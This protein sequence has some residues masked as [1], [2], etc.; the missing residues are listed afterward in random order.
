MR[1]D[2]D[3]KIEIL[4]KQ[5]AEARKEVN[6]LKLAVRAENLKVKISSEYSNF[7]LWEYD[8]ADDICYQYKK[9]DGIY[10][11]DLEPIVH[12]RDSIIGWG[13]V[14]SDDIPVFHKF[15]DAME[16][17][18][19]EICYDV[20]VVNDY[21]EIVW[22]RYEGKTIYDDNGN[23]LR[24]V[25]RTLDVTDKKGG[26]GISSDDRRDP[27]TGAYTYE[28]FI[29]TAVRRAAE[30]DFRNSALIVV[31]I[32]RFDELC[33]SDR[34]DTDDVQ[35]S[36][37]KVLEA[38]SSVEQGS[39]FARVDDGLFVYYVKFSD[40]PNLNAIASRLIY[41]F[42]D[43]RLTD[44]ETGKRITISAGISLF[45]Y[46]RKYDRIYDEALAALYAAALKGGNGYLQYNSA[47]SIKPKA[48]DDAQKAENFIG[49]VGAEKIYHII[50]SAITDKANSRTLADLAIQQVCK[51][52]NS[53]YAYL[54]H[55]NGDTLEPD[56]I[57]NADS[58]FEQSDGL[59]AT[60]PV[61]TRSEMSELLANNKHV[62]MATDRSGHKNYGFEFVNGAHNAMVSPIY[63]R[64]K[65]TY[66]LVFINDSAK[67]WQ[68]A[69]AEIIDMLA[70]ALSYIADREQ[71][72]NR[73]QEKN[74][75]TN[76]VVNG[77][78][79]EAFTIDPDTFIV[80]KAGENTVNEYGI[81]HGDICYKKLRGLE[82][83]CADCPVHQINA[84]QITAT[85]V[86]YNSKD[87]RWLNVAAS[88][89]DTTDG[90]RRC[91]VST[92]DMTASLDKIQSRD[93][94]TGVLGF[95]RFAVDA[96]RIT[97]QNSECRFVTVVNI[98]N[99]RRLNENKGYEFGNSV[100]IAVS[101]ILNGSLSGDELICRSE[102]AR[103]VIL[104]RN[105]SAD[106][107]LPRLKQILQSAQSQ[108]EEKC[109]IQIFLV[110][111][112]YQMSGD[113]IGIMASLDRAIIAQKTV[114]DKAYY[115][116]N[117]IVFY[118]KQLQDDLQTRQYIE[119]HM[120]EALENDEFKVFYQPKVNPE[121]GD[122]VGAEALVRWIRPDGEMISPGKFV[123]IFEQNGFIADMDFAIYRRAIADIKRWMRAGI[124]APL[125]SL[126]VS[127][128]HMMDD[129]FPDKICALV[130]NL[131]VPRSKI[132]L[133]ITESML[134]ENMNKL[135]DSM[136]CLKNAGFH[137]SVDDFG[138]GYSSLNLIT[139]LPFDTLKI[140]GGFFLRNKLTEKNKAVITSVMEMAK[141]LNLTTVSEGVETDEQVEFLR[142][143]GCDMIQGYYYYKP[144]PKSDFEALISGKNDA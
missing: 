134:T 15:C 33:E 75:F 5:L 92:V 35:R 36:V 143:L 116:T 65:L 27:L 60:V 136:T 41:R 118:D 31:G 131:G 74:R 48:K 49:A 22:F 9:L 11:N 107:L 88:L 82:H 39:L 112:I 54:Y 8:I 115:N 12:F 32:D 46:S 56:L 1:N 83:P 97:A 59:P 14:Y 53:A 23:P 105:A 71:Q 26:T 121:T 117:M 19:K 67:T 138:S 128:H 96:M 50:N 87:N 104:F 108:V 58:I 132:E 103:F 129:T 37:A 91:A 98:A 120:N 127:R 44:N 137:I 68:T 64:N 85:S 40:I 133:E 144:M 55:Y 20:R 109:G 90:S 111:G 4:E 18:D 2:I 141:N 45:G 119:S 140:D 61:C 52:T 16:R 24:V 106:E 84:G 57:C 25:G 79:V 135:L 95:D 51:Y 34:C 47:M 139:L 76:A 7:G 73:L 110:A 101:D 77:L 28:A 125:I 6:A 89:M 66:I 63:V 93:T 10:E 70:C 142:S 86:H 123:P 62:S 17:G 43:F 113:N 130:D 69:D 78:G 13:T 38:Q 80:D 42:H 99:F 126:N 21:S 100:L 122:I 124:E 102:G 3:L 114:K 94:L 29:E 30:K 81:K 72:N